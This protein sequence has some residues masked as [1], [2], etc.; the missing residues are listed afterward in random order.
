MATHV[1]LNP[2]GLLDATTMAYSQVMVS[3]GT[4]FVQIAGQAAIDA[5]FNVI[6][7]GDFA[8][9]TAA[10]MANLAIALEAA[11]AGPADVN[12]VRIYVVDL[13]AE[14]IPV[15]QDALQRFF[16]AGKLPTGTLVGVAALAIPGLLIEIEATAIQ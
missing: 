5:Q 11:G 3:S 13:R 9:Q 10:V 14:C 16:G 4:R 12:S 8:A 2:Q 15:L 1:R 6:A 7:A